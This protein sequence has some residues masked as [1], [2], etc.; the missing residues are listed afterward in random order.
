[1]DDGLL[2]FYNGRR[3]D[4]KTGERD[5]S[6]NIVTMRLDGFA[7]F[8]VDKLA[9]R[10][11]SKS[12]FLQTQPIV[13]TEDEFQINIEGH[14]GSARVALF[15]EN[16]QPIQGREFENCLPIDED[17]VRFPVLWK[18]RQDISELKGVPI[19][20]IVQFTSGTLYSLRF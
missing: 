11:H 2:F 4:A 8:T 19:V 7:G 3:Y 6:M 18:K 1:M 20:A 14:R 15:H 10:R 17:V 13:V 9:L 5:C 12:P 16:L